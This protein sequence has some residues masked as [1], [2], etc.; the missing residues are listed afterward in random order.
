MKIAV[1]AIIPLLVLDYFVEEFF[2]FNFEGFSNRFLESAGLIYIIL[3]P[4][5]SFRLFIHSLCHLGD[6]DEYFLY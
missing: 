1:G 4:C 6:K 5:F 3:S 2:F